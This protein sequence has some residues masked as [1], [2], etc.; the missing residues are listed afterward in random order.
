MKTV[1]LDS[2]EDRFIISIDKKSINKDALL[3]FLE[4]LRLEALADKVN[5]G[6]EIEDLGEEIKGDWWQSNKDRFIPKSEQ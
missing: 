3:Q 6:K 2:S 4:N 1:T 5:F